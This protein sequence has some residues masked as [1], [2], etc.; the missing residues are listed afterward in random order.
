ML[1]IT[2]RLAIAFSLIGF[3]SSQKVIH[4]SATPRINES[5]M[6]P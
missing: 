3:A 2:I 4:A 1:R 6:W 5:M